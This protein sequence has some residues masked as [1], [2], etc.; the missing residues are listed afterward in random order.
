MF[1]IALPLEGDPKLL[2]CPNWGRL[3][4]AVQ[5]V[6]LGFLLVLP[7]V[8]VAWLYRYEMRLVRPFAARSLLALR[9]FVIF[10]LWCIVGLQPSLRYESGDEIPPRVLIA[11][12]RSDSM[13]V[14][15]P[16]RPNLEKLR[17]ARALKLKVSGDM[18]SEAMLD[19]WIRQYQQKGPGAAIQWITE[20]FN[21][22]TERRTKLTEE[23]KALHDKLCA[24]V[25]QLTRTSIARRILDSGG[26]ELLETL[27]KKHKMKVELVGFHQKA[28]DLQPDQLDELF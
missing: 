5:L 20:E 10:F 24:Q 3:D 14:A 28:W 21:G 11:V 2:L 6:V 15:D 19:D 12:D 22:D 4:P 23:R 13:D 17:L 16:Q 7:L 9:L 1:R 8:L 26:V 27:T 25:D 18:P